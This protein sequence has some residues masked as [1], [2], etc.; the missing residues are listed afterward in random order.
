VVWVVILVALLVAG[1]TSALLVWREAAAASAARIRGAPKAAGFGQGGEPTPVERSGEVALKSF[2]EPD[3]W[4]SPWL[5]ALRILFLALLMAA[6]A[7]AV[8]AALFVLGRW[9]G[10]TLRRFVIQG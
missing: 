1:G 9:A 6:A 3:Y 5:R 8:A 7:A 4:R 2:L 10:E